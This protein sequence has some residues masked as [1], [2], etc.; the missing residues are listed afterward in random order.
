[1]K[2]GLALITMLLC[3]SFAVAAD[4]PVPIENW[5][6]QPDE[7]FKSDEGKRVVD[8]IISWQN[9]N[10]GWWKTYNTL[11]PRPADAKPKES[12][13]APKSDNALTWAGGSTIDNG[14][15]FN[16]LR[17]LARAHRV[18]GRAD[19]RDAFNKGMQFLFESQYPNGGWPQRYPLQNNYG[20]HITFNDNAMAGV[21]RVMRDAA[22]GKKDYEFVDAAMRQKARA[23]FD[24]AVDCVLNCQIKVGEKLTVW[25]QQ[26][27]EVT[28][29]PAA[30]R[31]FEP[32]ALCSTESAELVL[33][34]MDIEKPD[35][36]V[37][38]AIASAV[39]W[40]EANKITGKKY[41]KFYGPEYEKGFERRLVDDPAAPPLW[42]RM[43]DIATSKPIF[44]DRDG[45]IHDKVGELSYE[46]QAGY[47]W[48][49]IAPNKVLEA[50][51]KWKAK[52]G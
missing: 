6:D 22:E 3:A 42:A 29:A 18:I 19:A 40:F 23:S 27:D 45:S 28:F 38:R 34:L 32:A 51:P 15:T 48:Y 30:A 2:I 37:K 47:A 41:D 36:R 49:S 12:G 46:R 17:V 25:C 16:E 9:A 5:R 26:H 7:W 31:T 10:G 44:V 24:R 50:Y 20:R 14:A 21:M 43:S 13:L 8:N 35:D 4:K 33:I 39:A 11:E 1:M 52:N